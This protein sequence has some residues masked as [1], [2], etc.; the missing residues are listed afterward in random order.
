[1][2][3]AGVEEEG[4]WCLA[5]PARPPGDA[6][7]S[8]WSKAE[9]GGGREQGKGSCKAELTE[10]EGEVA[11]VGGESERWDRAQSSWR[12]MGARA[13]LREEQGDVESGAGASSGERERPIGRGRA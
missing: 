10:E 9:A 13:A 6:G 5:S 4:G 12:S 3:G 7:D 8:W 11:P 2:D 1:M